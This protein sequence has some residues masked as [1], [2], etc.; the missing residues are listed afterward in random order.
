VE[1]G[2]HEGCRGTQKQYSL[3]QEI[4]GDEKGVF[5]TKNLELY[6][7]GKWETPGEVHRFGGH[8]VGRSTD[9]KAGIMG[10]KTG[11]KS[12]TEPLQVLGE[13][14]IEG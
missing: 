11:S 12:S 9:C 4:Y 7:T 13:G 2:E 8:R 14:A 5:F 10:G 6:G 1:D 3:M